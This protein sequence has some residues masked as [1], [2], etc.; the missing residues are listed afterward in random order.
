MKNSIFVMTLLA[1]CFGVLSVAGTSQQISSG[2]EATGKIEGKVWSHDT[3][4]P[5]PNVEI[6]LSRTGKDLPDSEKD[7][8]KIKTDEKGQYSFS[9]L[10]PGEYY[11]T[12]RA[13]YCRKEDMPCRP[14][15]GIKSGELF[16]FVANARTADGGIIDIAISK[17]MTIAAG[18][19]V[20]IDIELWCE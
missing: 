15:L 10:K 17:E 18:G 13:K 11:I 7:A 14:S 20:K 9:S 16:G 3:K 5:I 1:A 19:L 6:L 2:G 4:K 8:G 12:V